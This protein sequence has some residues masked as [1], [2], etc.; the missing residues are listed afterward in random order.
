M[1]RRAGEK[2]AT[3]KELL[4]ALKFDESFKNAMRDYY[5]YG[6]KTFKGADK[7]V[8]DDWKRL[9]S[10]LFDCLE[11]KKEKRKSDKKE[12][13]FA[14]VDS[15]ALDQNPFQRLYRFCKYKHL[16]YFL[17]TMFAFELEDDF[18]T[19][20]LERAVDKMAISKKTVVLEGEYCPQ[21]L[22]RI[23]EL[24]EIT[25]KQKEELKDAVIHGMC[26]KT[27]QISNYFP[28][29]PSSMKVKEKDKNRTPNNRLCDIEEIG[30]IECIQGKGRK[31]S[32]GDRY[33]KKRGITIS[34]LLEFGETVNQDFRIHFVWAL[35]FFSKY[36]SLGEIGLFLLDRI[37]EEYHSVLRFKNEYYMH[38]LNDF[39]VIDIIGVIE[40]KEWCR[41]SYQHGI[42]EQTHTELLCFPL[43]IRTSSATG[44]QTL[45]VYEP[46]HRSCTGLRIEF[47]DEIF[48]YNDKD[49]RCILKKTG[50]ELSEEEIDSDIGN[51]RERLKYT[52]GV[53]TSK[54]QLEN[55]V[56]KPVLQHVSIG[57]AYEDGK[58][59]Y[60]LNRL[61]REKRN[62]RIIIDKPELFMS[63]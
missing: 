33:W 56:E 41:I 32:F 9:N 40:R 25:D 4:T 34:N 63:I 23:I 57:I 18:D 12:I 59:F 42:K 21:E 35:D 58:D 16:D 2:M 8:A 26:L 46:F 31:G 36:F 20:Y 27:A 50:V 11:W 55:V 47:I 5:S 52:W 44:R 38:A 24:L 15:Q 28:I 30:L 43:E 51:A 3:H 29:T 22:F 45:M 39:N 14:S 10:I 61:K 7:T 60:I 1:K 53:S 49:I 19:G 48:C 17:H 37:N 62:G 6:F 54:E 13:I